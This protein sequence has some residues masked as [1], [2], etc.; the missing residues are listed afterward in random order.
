LIEPNPVLSTIDGDGAPVIEQ[1]N[2]PLDLCI[3]SETCVPDWDGK[4]ADYNWILAGLA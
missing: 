1:A 2:Q 4:L 3:D